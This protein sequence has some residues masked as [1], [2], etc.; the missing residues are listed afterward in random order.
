MKRSPQKAVHSKMLQ[1]HEVFYTLQ[2]E[3]PFI[4]HP[5]VFVRFTG[6]NLQCTWCDTEWDDDNDHSYTPHE[7]LHTIREVDPSRN[8]DLIVFTGGEPL[9]Q[10]LTDVASVLLTAGFKIQVETAGSYFQE[11]VN[12]DNVFVVISPKTPKVNKQ[13]LEYPIEKSCWKYVID[14]FKVSE[15]DGLPL[16]HPQPSNHL[17][18]APLQ[19]P[20]TN[21]NVY[22]SVCDITEV[23]ENR[24]RSRNLVNEEQQEM[25]LHTRDIALKHGHKFTM[26][27]HKLLNIR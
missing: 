9:R 1:I 15:E 17:K 22:V 14:N 20:P 24:N 3:G 26:Q 21:A 16:R 5:A 25:M 13:W 19:R 2:G 7:I 27:L 11:W 8:A 4:G 10:D 12:E 6:C 18:Q 23:A